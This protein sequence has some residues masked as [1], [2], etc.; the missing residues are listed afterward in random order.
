MKTKTH[1]R[2]I[3]PGSYANLNAFHNPN[4]G[5]E[6]SLIKTKEEAQIALNQFADIERDSEHYEYWQK[7]KSECRL[8]RVTEIVEDD[9]DSNINYSTAPELLYQLQHT[10]E[11]LKTPPSERA[12]G[13]EE[14]RIVMLEEAIKKATE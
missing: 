1:F 7:T 14:A 2:V 11:M 13:I 6:W 10:L 8:V 9:L 12:E 3:P 4:K 5:G